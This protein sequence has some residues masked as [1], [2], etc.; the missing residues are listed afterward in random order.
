MD[1]I[2]PFGGFFQVTPAMKG[3]LANRLILR[4]NSCCRESA[5]CGMLPLTASDRALTPVGTGW[6]QNPRV[7]D[8]T[9]LLR[10]TAR[11]KIFHRLPGGSGRTLV[12]QEHQHKLIISVKIVW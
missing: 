2:H 6:L 11:L 5:L 8:T 10:I 4:R 1:G 9:V 3:A 7:H 12:R